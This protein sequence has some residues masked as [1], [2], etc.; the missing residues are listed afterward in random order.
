MRSLLK[1]IYRYTHPRAYR[2]NENLWP[3][4]KIERAITGEIITFSY[5]GLQVPIIELSSLK[6]SCSGSLLL[7][8]TGP[9]IN[10]IDFS[11]IPSLAVMGVN[12]AYHLNYVLNFTHYV[13]VDMTFIDDRKEVVTDIISNA[14]LTL[15]T[16]AY[17]IIKLIQ[18]FGWEKVQC[19]LA[20][21]EDAAFKIYQHKIVHSDLSTIPSVHFHHNLSNIAFNTDIRSGVIDSGTVAYWAMQIAYYLG[22][23]QLFIAGLDMTNFNLPRFYETSNDVLPS[24]LAESLD[25]K[26]IPSFELAARL[27][28]EKNIN[29]VNISENSAIDDAIFKKINYRQAFSLGSD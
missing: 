5:K 14:S 4:L 29:I 6:N 26:I 18:I 24:R 8:A 12:G 21:I 25:S 28:N 16:T 15:F 7:V 22:Y 23:E 13:I 17:G 2:H 3:Y 27:F 11:C 1:Q 10:Q 19:R 9:S 20:L